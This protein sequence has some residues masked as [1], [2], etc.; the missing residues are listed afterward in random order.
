MDRYGKDGI[1]A[2]VQNFCADLA[3]LKDWNN[4]DARTLARIINQDSN[5]WD[6]FRLMDEKTGSPGIGYTTRD[7]TK[8]EWFHIMRQMRNDPECP[9]LD[10]LG[11]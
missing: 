2:E 1:I 4:T 6:L 3:E 9:F 7:G 10:E 8:R 11:R 5:P